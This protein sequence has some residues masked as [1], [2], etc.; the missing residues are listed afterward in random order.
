M[1]CYNE[2]LP[3]VDESEVP[4]IA[5]PGN[6]G[7][8]DLL[9]SIPELKV[10]KLYEDSIVPTRGSKKSAGLD[11][12]AFLPNIDCVIDSKSRTLVKTGIAIAIPD[13]YYGRVAPRSACL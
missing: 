9:E 8:L 13:G 3:S 10:Q 11:L 12:Y 2:N 4:D 6:Q 7:L 1:F 5:T